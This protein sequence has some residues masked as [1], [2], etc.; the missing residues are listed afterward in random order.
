[1]TVKSMTGFGSA[2]AV[3]RG[4]EILVEISSVNRKQADIQ[5]D[6][7]RQLVCVES[8]F[9]EEIRKIVSSGRVNCKVQMNQ[10]GGGSCRNMHIDEKLAQHYL[11][12]IRSAA[13][14]LKLA[15]EVSTEYLM[16]LPG[17]VVFYEPKADRDVLWPVCRRALSLALRQFDLM[18]RTEGAA[19]AEDIAS[20]LTL[21]EK[22]IRRIAVRAPQTVRQ[23]RK[24]LMQRISSAGVDTADSDGRLL[25]EIAL[26]ADRC[27]ISE[28]L[29]RL[30]SHFKQARSLMAGKNPAGRS[31]D[32]LA[33]EMLREFN[34]IGSKA[35]DAVIRGTVVT[36]KAELERLREQVQNIE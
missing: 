20:R 35:H 6:L 15:Q 5:L 12:R 29:T 24:T 14:R 9:G 3:G 25:R 28:E 36:C 8:L 16:G 30:D 2:K 33:Q 1:M 4:F 31:L 19:L 21:M 7:P 34:T 10:S 11:S 27:D 18:R 23:Y 26:F 22:L 13:R 32:F 17:V